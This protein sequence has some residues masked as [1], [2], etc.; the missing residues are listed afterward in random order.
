MDQ[1]LHGMAMGL[2]DVGYEGKS[3][4]QISMNRRNGLAVQSTE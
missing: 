2:D 1:L 3:E 4:C